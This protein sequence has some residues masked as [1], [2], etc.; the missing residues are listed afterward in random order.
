[1]NSYNREFKEMKGEAHFDRETLNEMQKDLVLKKKIE[2]AAIIRR[3]THG[4]ESLNLLSRHSED[5]NKNPEPSS[6]K[7]S[8]KS[9]SA[10]SGRMC[11]L[12]RIYRDLII[13]S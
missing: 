4:T 2:L 9:T 8:P 11:T 13:I 12:R 3:E 10:T 1:M 5:L 6:S 7:L